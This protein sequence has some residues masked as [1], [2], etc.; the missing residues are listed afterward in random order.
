MS[1]A[2]AL[3]RPELRCP[4]FGRRLAMFGMALAP[5]R[6]WPMTQRTATKE[7]RDDIGNDASRAH[8]KAARHQARKRLEL[9][10]YLRRDRRHVAGARYRSHSRP[11]EIDQAAGSQGRRTVRLEQGRTGAAQ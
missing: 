5:L 6:P 2:A 1:V 10:T 3:R 11:D 7:T 4:L 8:R 9:E